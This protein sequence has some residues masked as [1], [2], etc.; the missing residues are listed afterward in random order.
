MLSQQS[1]TFCLPKKKNLQ[2]QINLGLT[3]MEKVALSEDISRITDASDIAL[4]LNKVKYTKRTNRVFEHLRSLKRESFDDQ[5]TRF[6]N[7]PKRFF[8]ELNRLTGR[9]KK[10]S[11]FIITDN[12]NKFNT[13]D[14]AVSNLFNE[15]FVSI[16]ETWI[17]PVSFTTERL[18]S[19]KKFFFFYPTDSSE[20]SEFVQNLKNNEAAELDGLTV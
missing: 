12:K 16:S 2:N 10:N 3:K 9:L 7:S 19:N 6:L 4:C 17:S 13:G 11:N 1:S 14:F 15:K 18:A 8:N 5:L 20:I